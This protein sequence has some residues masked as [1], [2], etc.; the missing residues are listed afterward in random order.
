[1]T[2][3][4]TIILVFSLD[5][6]AIAFRDFKLHDRL[7][8]NKNFHSFSARDWLQ[9]VVA[10]HYEDR[11]ISFNY[12]TS[13]FNLCQLNDCGF[14]DRCEASRSLLVSPGAIFHQ[15]RPVSF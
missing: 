1:M 13:S 7:L 9:C 5:P 10:C 12:D 3:S 8:A 2:I 6:A 14:H 4:L 15:L 11:C